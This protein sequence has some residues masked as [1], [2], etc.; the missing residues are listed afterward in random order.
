MKMSTRTSSSESAASTAMAAPQTSWVV[1]SRFTGTAWQGRTGV[2]LRR[3]PEP[4]WGWPQLRV[5]R[6]N[7]RRDELERVALARREAVRQRGL[8][9]VDHLQRTGARLVEGGGRRE[10]AADGPGHG[11]RGDRARIERGQA[12]V[13]LAR[14]DEGER[15]G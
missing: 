10:P 12:G 6:H 11:R 1:R 4:A 2:A 7:A 13:A 14:E 5:A 15:H 3:A 9:L 8:R